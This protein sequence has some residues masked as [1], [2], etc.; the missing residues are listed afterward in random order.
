MD[1]V[2]CSIL[3]D[4]GYTKFRLEHMLCPAFDAVALVKD[5]ICQRK[6][7]WLA[8]LI[9]V[10]PDGIGY[11]N[12]SAKY[13]SHFFISGT[14]TGHLRTLS[15]RHVTLVSNWDIK[16]NTV[17]SIGPIY[18]SSESMT[19]AALYDCS[20]AVQAVVHVHSQELWET[21]AGKV[22]TT[23]PQVRYGTPE[24]AVEFKALYEDSAWFR[25]RGFAVMGGHT[26]GLIS[27]G[28][29]LREASERILRK[30]QKV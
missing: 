3:V 17:L 24:M 1:G 22:P 23:N 20:S 26:D 11:G 21:C 25:E 28:R 8:G 14:Q 10:L 19:H 27:V 13:G 7:L 16:K 12:L 9:G 29:T 5:I 2:E 30:H 15:N 18:P 6:P 4:E